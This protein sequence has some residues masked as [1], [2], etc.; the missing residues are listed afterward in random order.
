MTRFQGQWSISAN[1]DSPMALCSVLTHAPHAGSL[2]C[3]SGMGQTESWER[4]PLV[5]SS[6][7]LFWR[8][9]KQTLQI[10]GRF[11]RV[12]FPLF[13]V[14]RVLGVMSCNDPNVVYD[15]ASRKERTLKLTANSPEIRPKPAKGEEKIVYSYSSFTHFFRDFCC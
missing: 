5:I 15:V 10:Y 4:K 6:N 9:I 14:G 3:T 11:W 13:F 2:L 8:G 7:F 1:E 12:P